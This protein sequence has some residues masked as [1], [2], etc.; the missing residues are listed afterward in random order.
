MDI[1]EAITTVITGKS[2]TMSDASDV[3]LEIM[4]G[5]A[6]PAQMG[7]FLTALHQ[8]GETAEEIAGMALIMRDKA[9]RVNVSHTLTDTCGTGGDGKNTFNIS[10]ATAFVAAGCGLHIAKHGNRASSGSCG[11]ADVLEA[12]GVK[13]DLPPESVEKCINEVGIGFMFAPVFHPSMR[14]A[15]PVRR[16]IGIPT[17]FNILGPLTNPAFAQHQ[18]LGIGKSD[19]GKTMAEV[20]ALLGTEHAIVVHGEDGIDEL[21]LSGDTHVWEVVGG[22]VKSWTLTVKETGLPQSCLESIQGGTPSQN[23]ETMRLI[24]QGNQNP[25]RD[26]VLLNTAAVLLGANQVDNISRGIEIAKEAIDTG[27][28]LSKMNQLIAMTTDISNST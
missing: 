15:G 4:D 26:V 1:R 3:M 13:I 14:H 19:L 2:L 28:A 18:L 27:I 5:V 24:F 16:E 8:K 11:S 20:L 7:A 10:T 22:S 9:L 12:L 6:T 25:L 17:V 23:A 21:T